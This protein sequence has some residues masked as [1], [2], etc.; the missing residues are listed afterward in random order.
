MNEFSLNQPGDML[1]QAAWGMLGVGSGSQD[2]L[3]VD[4]VQC[5][6]GVGESGEAIPV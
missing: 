5:E 2:T 6:A 4:A 1:G 3:V